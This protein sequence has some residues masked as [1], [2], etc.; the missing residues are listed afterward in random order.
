MKNIF[1]IIFV[2]FLFSGC[3]K[4]DPQKART[5]VENLLA[6][7]KAENYSSLDKYY[8]SSFNDTEPTDKKVEKLKQLKETVGSIKSFELVSSK[9]RFNQDSNINELE[10]KYKIICE[11]TTVEETYLIINDEGDL[12][13][14][15]QN[16][17]NLK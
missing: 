17:E 5:L 16:I 1:L 4:I 8:S 6:D 14:I 7:R 11:R 10:L 13:I 12:K 9:E 2:A 15:F 3:G